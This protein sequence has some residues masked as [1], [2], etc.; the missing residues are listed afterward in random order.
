MNLEIISMADVA[1]VRDNIAPSNNFLALLFPACF[2][3]NC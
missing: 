1:E 3:Q 2:H